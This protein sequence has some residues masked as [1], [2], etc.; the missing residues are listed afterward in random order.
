MLGKWFFL[1]GATNPLCVT[2]QA[3]RYPL[4]VQ[5]RYEPTRGVAE[6]CEL[7]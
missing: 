4:T 3:G 1:T 5:M 2:K 7:R 6:K